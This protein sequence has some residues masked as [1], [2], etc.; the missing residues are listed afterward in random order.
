MIGGREGEEGAL[1]EGH[2]GRRRGW[3]TCGLSAVGEEEGEEGGE[4][5][6]W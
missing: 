6:R 3:D 5:K 2:V 1:G 4:E